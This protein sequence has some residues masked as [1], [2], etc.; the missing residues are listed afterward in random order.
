MSSIVPFLPLF[1]RELG[2]TGVEET[3]SWSGWVFAGP[4]FISLFMTPL[5]GSLGDKYGRKIISIRAVLGLGIA[6]I[7]IGLAQSPTQL[8]V[9]RFIQGGLSGFSPAAMAMVAANTP[10]EK[11]SYALGLLQT[12]TATGTVIGPLIGGVL[13]D[14]VGY[15]TV[16]FIVAS[17]LI[18]TG[19]FFA[20]YVKEEKRSVSGQKRFTLLENAKFIFSKKELRYIIYLILLT[21]FAFAFIRPIFVLF[22]EDILTTQKFFTTITGVLYGI[23]GFF[24]AIAAPLWGKYAQ[25]NGIRI[26]IIYASVLTGMMYFL[27]V[28]VPDAY[29]LAPVRALLGF[30]YGGLLPVMFAAISSYTPENRK[31]GVMGLG[32][33]AQILGNM[34]GPSLSGISVALAGIKFPFLVSGLTF[35]IMII[36]GI[37]LKKGQ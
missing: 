32:S 27:H 6:Q 13:A 10:E 3:A 8:L 14:M 33:S 23:S 25:K 34:I 18:I 28:I 4:F 35:I 31:S 9:F 15:R 2:V 17:L 11:N 24:T 29:L 37:K 5:W 19:I 20:I 16:F 36:I 26:V 12:A 22:V 30:G 7:L 1:I 21:S